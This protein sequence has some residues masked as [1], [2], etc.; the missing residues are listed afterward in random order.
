MEEVGNTEM[1]LPVTEGIERVTMAVS[2]EAVTVEIVS[3]VVG[4]TV[5]SNIVSIRELIE[6]NTVVIG[7]LIS[8]GES[9]GMLLVVKGGVWATTAG[10]VLGADVTI[11]DVGM[12][13]ALLMKEVRFTASMLSG[14]V[15]ILGL[16]VGNAV[17]SAEAKLVVV[18]GEGI[19]VALITDEIV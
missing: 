16:G 4:M 2:A 17:V 11:G 7:M 9:R 18:G 10:L 19:I 1:S 6:P 3:G 12:G 14:V 13:V 5:L 15:D 8:V